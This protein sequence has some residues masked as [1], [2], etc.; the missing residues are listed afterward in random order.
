[1]VRIET[2]RVFIFDVLRIE[3]SSMTLIK[4][5]IFAITVH[6]IIAIAHV[7]ML[8]IKFAVNDRS[9]CQPFKIRDCSFGKTFISSR[10]FT[11]P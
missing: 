9:I 6:T 11:L 1:M 4:I 2:P 10:K 5:V 3:K 8:D 7:A